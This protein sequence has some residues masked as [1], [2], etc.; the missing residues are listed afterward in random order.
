M[1]KTSSILSRR[2]GTIIGSKL[3]IFLDALSLSNGSLVSCPQKSSWSVLCLH[4]DFSCL[5]VASSLTPVLV[6]WDIHSRRAAFENI[7]HCSFCCLRLVIAALFECSASSHTA[8]KSGKYF[9]KQ[10]FYYGYPK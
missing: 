2:V 6:T 10:L 3:L 5:A 4:N 8:E 9:R 1:L 7:S